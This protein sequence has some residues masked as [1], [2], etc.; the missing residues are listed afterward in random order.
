MLLGNAIIYV[1]GLLWLGSVVGWDKP[2][3][4]WGMTPFLLGDL[5]KLIVAALLMPSIWKLLSKR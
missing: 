4:Q 5:A 2:V 1:P 3:L